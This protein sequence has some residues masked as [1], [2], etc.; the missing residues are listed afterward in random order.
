MKSEVHKYDVVDNTEQDKTMA[1]IL[2]MTLPHVERLD[3]STGYFNVGGY[4]LLRETLENSVKNNSFTIRLLLGKEAMAGAHPSFE[5]E[6]ATYGDDQEH[7]WSI[8]ED[9]A[10]GDLTS[11]LKTNTASLIG[12]LKQPNVHVRLGPDRFNHSKCY[13]LGNTTAAFIGS[14]NFTRSGL[15]SNYE[16]NAGLYQPGAIGLTRSWFER[17]WNKGSNI[18]EDLIYDLTRSKFGAPAS[19]YEIYMKILFEKYKGVLQTDDD[20]IPQLTS[21]AEFQRDAVVALMRIIDEWGG[22]ML[23]DSTGLGK[24]HIGIEV[25]KRKMYRDGAKILLIAPAQIL[26]TVWA[27][28]LKE[29]G[30]V[31]ETI[32]TERLGRDI[33]VAKYKKYNLVVIDESQK[34]RSKL[35]NRRKNLMQIMSTGTKQALL[36][37]ATPINNTIM[38]LYYQLSIITGTGKGDEHFLNL[39]I[40][41]L[42]Q[43]LK[44]A[45]NHHDYSERLEKIQQLLDS[46]MVRR[47]RTYIEE[48]YKDTK[49]A[50]TTIKFP[51]REYAPIRYSLT[52]LF[53]DDI[54]EILFKTIE[55]LNMTPYAIERYNNSLTEEERRTHR[56]LA[57]LQIFSLLKRF[58]SSVKAVSISLDSRIKLFERFEGVLSKNKIMNAKEL[59]KIIRLWSQESEAEDEE[60][61]EETRHKRFLS[62]ID[63]LSLHDASDY[64]IPL[65]SK[66]IRSDLNLLREYKNLVTKMLPFD[67]KFDAVCETIQRD[68]ALENESKKVLVFTEYAA[69]A[70]YIHKEFKKRFPNKRVLVITGETNGNERQR[71]ITQ[72]SPRSNINNGDRMPKQEGDILVSTEVLAEGQNLQ[73][74]NYVIN[75]DLPWNPMKI[76]QRIGRI[77]R[78]TSEYSTVRSRECYPD[79]KLD[80]L[81]RLMAKIMIKISDVK[82]VIGLD[83]DILDQTADP[84]QYNE[85]K[86][87]TIRSFAEGR[88]EYEAVKIERELDLMPFKSHMNE[89]SRYIRELGAAKVME[90]PMGRR[91]GKVGEG[92]KIA[93][94]YVQKKSHGCV[95]SVVYDLDNKSAEVVDNG[96][97][98]QLVMCNT[99]TPLYMPMDGNDYKESFDMLLKADHEA[100][101]VIIEKFERSRSIVEPIRNQDRADTKYRNTVDEIKHILITEMSNGSIPRDAANDLLSILKSPSL[102]AWTSRVEQIIMEYSTKKDVNAFVSKMNGLGSIMRTK[103]DIAGS[104]MTVKPSDLK[105]VGAVFI[106]EEVL[107]N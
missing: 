81:L 85:N 40:P 41:H 99:D 69:T 23:A 28:K 65:M 39:G 107:V 100:R 24:T 52:H 2:N 78:L 5:R 50:N 44:K 26:N 96:V 32:G 88:G 47:T 73:D 49:L 106:T 98:I 46:V 15:L 105:L 59:G 70:N 29:S 30:I 58:E 20:E 3:I 1:A 45:A 92:R 93:L 36:L 82:D 12:I 74:C 56:N 11:E 95:H 91:S 7:T 10:Y 6:A 94:A 102:I 90:F 53:G 16:L 75:Y 101:N 83:T 66:H 51:K 42:R 34:F 71:R 48:G 103:S 33:D 13:I 14:S 97:L 80:D 63:G 76:V 68:G 61:S 19:P 55:S 18:K 86:I 38:D 22:A 25:I 62:K 89:I 79:T 104:D 17:M 31:V 43:Y 9:L 67:K 37:S 57:R 54:Y 72:F 87:R 77:D 27:A 21:L 4:A 64:N 8:Q 84:K 60:E 35:A